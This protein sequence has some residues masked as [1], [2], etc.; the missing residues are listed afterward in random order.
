MSIPRIPGYTTSDQPESLKD[1]WP[2]PPGDYPKELW[3][4]DTLNI[5]VAAPTD[6]IPIEEYYF[7]DHRHGGR[8]AVLV[9]AADVSKVLN[10]DTW[11]GDGLGSIGIWTNRDG[12]QQFDKGL[13]V[14]DRDIE[15]DFLVQVRQQHGLRNPIVE[16]SHSFLWYWDAIESDDGWYYLDQAGQDQQLIRYRV[17]MNAWRV[18]VRALELRR[19][20]ADAQQVLVAQVDHVS[21]VAGDAFQ[22]DE[23]SF[24][25]DWAQFNWWCAVDLLTGDRPHTS[26]LLGKYIISGSMSAASPRWDRS[27]EDIIHPEFVY[28]IDSTTGCS[29][30]H[31]CDPDQLGSYFDGDD[32]H[33]HYLTPVNFSPNVLSKYTSE[34]DRYHVEPGYLRCLDLWGVRFSFNTAGLVEVYLGDIGRDI[35]SQEWPHWV[36]HNVRPEG[37]M[38]E[39]RFR[40]DF[41]AQFASG[42]HPTE[43][44][45]RLRVEINS[46]AEPILGGPIWRE[47]NEPDKTE[48]ERLFPSTTAQSLKL[49]ILLLC[50]ALVEAI[51]QRSIVKY[52]GSKVPD[53]SRLSSLERLLDSL[54]GNREVL[55]PLRALQQ[56]RSKGGIAHIASSQR[57]NALRRLGIHGM[58]PMQAFETI[59]AR[60]RDALLELDTLL[61][62]ACDM[63]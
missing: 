45:K 50:K 38:S 31:T 12:H 53:E 5:I 54:G 10:D 11:I 49:A 33:I 19:Y 4:E 6:W 42:D 29:I 47:L 34:P 27:D 26:R 46:H 21:K 59:S 22:E 37:Q 8:G 17:T 57:P 23:S 48:F 1:L 61:V 15:V 63:S 40:R 2:P 35:P 52:L 30:K 3:P 56:V 28:G 39:D 32:S 41:L 20:L 9:E 58:S 44:L 36:T 7:E 13:T 25:N 62:Q 18:E 55:E 51:D 14:R 16:I 24:K 43:D 60:I